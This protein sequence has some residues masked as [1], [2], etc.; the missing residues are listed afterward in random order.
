[1]AD[2]ATSHPASRY[3]GEVRQTIPYYDAIQDECLDLVASLPQPPRA[4]LD[5]GCG[6][7]SLVARAQRLFPATV[8]VVADPSPAMLIEAGSRLDPARVTLLEPCPT[9]SLPRELGPFD[10]VTAIQC[11]HYLDAGGRRDAVGACFDLLAPG[12][13]FLTSENIRPLS[14]RGLSIGR[15]Y[16]AQFQ[17]RAGRTPP[18]IAAHLGRFDRE[19]FPL[20]VPEHLDLLRDAGFVAVEL[21]WVSYLQAVFYA[22]KGEE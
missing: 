17:E 1:M 9:G 13:L 15:R 6:T 4:W 5:T 22:V 12:G 11:H 16:W 3:D 10:L 8:F 14:S 18:E 20:T 7:G 19:Y 2:N 21:L